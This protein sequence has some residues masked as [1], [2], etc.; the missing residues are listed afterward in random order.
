MGRSHRCNKR[1]G[2]GSASLIECAEVHTT[3]QSGRTARRDD[4]QVPRKALQR[5]GP[6]QQG[7]LDLGSRLIDD[8]LQ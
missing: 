4:L 8:A 3:A 1:N 7:H 5:A 6:S 2:P